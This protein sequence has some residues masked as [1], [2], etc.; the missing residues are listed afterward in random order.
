MPKSNSD[1]EFES[2]KN[3]ISDLVKDFEPMA[4][5]EV[6]DAGFNKYFDEI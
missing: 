3:E 4:M 2:M 1:R 6:F 5:D